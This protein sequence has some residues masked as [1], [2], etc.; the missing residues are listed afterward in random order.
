DAWTPQRDLALTAPFGVH[1]LENR[2]L[3]RKALERTLGWPESEV[4]ILCTVSRITKAKGFGFLLRQAN[5]LLGR[6]CRLL[7]IGDGERRLVNRLHN[8]AQTHPHH[9]ALITPYS[10]TVARRVLAGA[11]ALLMPS[12]TEPCGLSQQQAQCYGCVPIVARVGGLT[13]TVSDGRTGFLFRPSDRTSFLAA[14]DRALEAYRASGWRSIQQSCMNAHDDHGDENAYPDLFEQ[15][16]RRSR[17]KQTC[18]GPIGGYRAA[19]LEL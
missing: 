7:F 1:D 2:R 15:L 4:P 14:V 19:V 6:G 3:N 17:R 10:E 16:I 5:E 12:L 9:V 18:D 13:D 8:L 11:D